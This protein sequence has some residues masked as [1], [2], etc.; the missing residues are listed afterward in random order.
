MKLS[1]LIATLE[2]RKAMFEALC[3]ALNSQPG[4]NGVQI[5]SYSDNGKMNIGAKRQR[6]LEMAAGDFIVFH[7]DDDRPS[8]DYVPSILAACNEG[9]DCI[10][11]KIDCYGYAKDRKKLET[12]VV[13][14][15]YKLWQTDVDGFR[16]V[17]ST[18]HLVPVRR[19]LALAAGFD[20][21]SK[22]GEDHAYSM[23]LQKL[24]IGQM[25][26][27][28]IDKVLYTILHNPN[29]KFGE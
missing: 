20:P 21:L 5:L 4:A 10:G 26:E 18:H 15:R 3:D 24:G 8:A 19:E 2:S 11:F 27:V 28:F 25:K 16:Y 22:Y 6:L 7:D 1:I 29:K 23:R 12:A 13:S 14:N 17:R 9:V